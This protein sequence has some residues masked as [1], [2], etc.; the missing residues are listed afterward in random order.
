MFYNVSRHQPRPTLCMFLTDP[1][2][3]ERFY[4]NLCYSF[5]HSVSPSVILFL[6]IFKTS[7]LSNL[8]SYEADIL[9][10]CSPP[11]TCH[12]SC[13]CQMSHVMGHMSHFIFFLQSD[14]ASCQRVCY[15]QGLPRLVNHYTPRTINIQVHIV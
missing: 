2:Q 12:M 10:D 15:Q 6:Q 5:I 3:P 4:K 7:L 9:R 14:G 11:T 13:M 1:V 8:K